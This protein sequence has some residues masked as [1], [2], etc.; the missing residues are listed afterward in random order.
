MGSKR[1]FGKTL[2]PIHG[3]P[4]LAYLIDSLLQSFERSKLFI[5]T[6]IS[7]DDDKIVEFCQDNKLNVFRGDEYN[8]ASRFKKIL[9]EN[10]ADYFLRLN[11]DSPLFDYRIAEDI[12]KTYHKLNFDNESIDLIST[13]IGRTFPSG[14]NVELL[15]SAAFLKAYENFSNPD[16]FEHVT[17]Y[18]YEV[19]KNFNIITMESRIENPE[20]YK[21]SFDTV[22][23]K[24]RIEKIFDKFNK[25]HYF[26]TLQE[27]CSIYKELFL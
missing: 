27:K 5:A 12:I 14:M 16:H 24:S 20:K 15:D 2:F 7:K 23:D 10:V 8:V 25:P 13:V 3:K 26:Y 18:F 6:S 4:S 17:K 22:E 21:F 9:E 1:F 11:A 19:V